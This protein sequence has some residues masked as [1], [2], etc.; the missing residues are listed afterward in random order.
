MDD[1][2]KVESRLMVSGGPTYTNHIQP[3]PRGAADWKEHQA[4]N[5]LKDLADQQTRQDFLNETKNLQVSGDEFDNDFSRADFYINEAEIRSRKRSGIEGGIVF[6]LEERINKQNLP[7][8]NSMLAR[9]VLIGAAGHTFRKN[10]LSVDPVV[11]P[12]SK[13]EKIS[14]IQMKTLEREASTQFISLKSPRRVK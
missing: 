9:D 1:G 5:Y 6:G 10:K 7:S 2:D 13:L 14:K 12:T 11:L 8:R 3:S 4:T